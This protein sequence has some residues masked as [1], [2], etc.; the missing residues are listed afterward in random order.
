MTMAAAAV[1]HYFPEFADRTE[2]DFV[3][4]GWFLGQENGLFF[5]IYI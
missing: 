1:P 4:F 2:F 5:A 3:G